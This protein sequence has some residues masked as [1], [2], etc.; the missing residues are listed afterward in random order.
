MPDVVGP[1]RLSPEPQHDPDRRFD[2][3]FEPLES[4]EANTDADRVGAPA[5]EL[6]DADNR[7]SRIAIRIG[8]AAV[9]CATIAA[10]VAT[11]ML[12]LRQPEPSDIINIPV[13]TS[14]PTSAAPPT[15]T[16]PAV[17][18]ATPEV[19]A[20][21]I[22]TPAPTVIVEPQPQLP[23]APT[24]SA[25]VP[26][27]PAPSP[28]MRPPISV[29]PEPHPPFPNQ[30]PSQDENQPGGLLPGGLPGPL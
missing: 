19:T 16:T 18:E 24:T 10:T 5:T 12:L 30:I 25:S 11:V 20:S 7:R 28:A 22:Q 17:L 26:E 3:L 2:Y 6:P 1:D 9:I 21:N 29:E 14:K 23:P 13:S 15:I 27:V 8:I 4:D